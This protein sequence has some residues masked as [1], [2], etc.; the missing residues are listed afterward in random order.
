MGEE[1]LIFSLTGAGAGVFTLCSLESRAGV[2]GCG[3][4]GSAWIAGVHYNERCTQ[5]KRSAGWIR[6]STQYNSITITYP[7]TCHQRRMG[8]GNGN[9]D[10]ERILAR[11]ASHRILEDSQITNYRSESAKV[12]IS[13]EVDSA[14]CRRRRDRVVGGVAVGADLRRSDIRRMAVGTSGGRWSPGAG[15]DADDVEGWG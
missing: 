15:A 8:M 5:R 7:P 9:G 12:S 6:I 11:F 14:G 3:D 13:G 1:G 10:Q 4:R 2:R